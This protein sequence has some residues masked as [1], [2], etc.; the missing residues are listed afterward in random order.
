VGKKQNIGAQ[1]ALTR[2]DVPAS[3]SLFEIVL[4][5]QTA[6]HDAESL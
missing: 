3:I 4:W 1:E 6:A 5:G 2:S